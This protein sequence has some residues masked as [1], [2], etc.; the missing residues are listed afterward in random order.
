[1]KHIGILLLLIV[2][3]N[4]LDFIHPENSALHGNGY[5]G[6]FQKLI[7]TACA[8]I[9]FCFLEAIYWIVEIFIMN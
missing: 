6:E 9:V 1:M 3:C 5:E 2:I 8:G 4:F 7:P